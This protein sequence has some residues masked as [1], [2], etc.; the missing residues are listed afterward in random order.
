M[1]APTHMAFGVLWA[2]VADAGYV[3][4]SACALGSL[5]PDDQD[6]DVVVPQTAPVEHRAEVPAEL[7]MTEM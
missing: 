6:L 5:L 7:L 3:H 2:S 4:A 1:T